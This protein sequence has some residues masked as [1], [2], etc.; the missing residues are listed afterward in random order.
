MLSVG[1]LSGI[2]IILQRKIFADQVEKFLIY[3][4]KVLNFNKKYAIIYSIRCNLS[5]RE[6]KMS[7]DKIT[8]LYCRLSQDDMLDGESNSI[9]NQKAIL[10]KFANDNGFKNTQFYV[11]DGF[12]GT[13]FNRPDFMRMIADVESGKVGIVITKDLSRLGRDYLLTGQYI[14]MIFPD[15]DVRYIAIND[16]VDTFKSENELM[17]FKNIFNDWYA[18]DTSKKIRAVFK[19]KG[20][21]GKPL[22]TN[23][24]YG[25]VKDEND[26]NH[27][28]ID[29]EA[30]DVV[31]RI[32][33]LCIDG[34]GP[35]KIARIL[36]EDG[37]LIPTAYAESKG[38]TTSG[39][40]FKKPTRWS[41]GT[42]ERILE[43]PEYIGHTVNFRT[44]VKSYKNKKRIDN[45]RSEWAIFENTHE[46][47]ISQHDFDL[48]QELRSHKH[49]PQ[50]CDKV[51]PFSGMV[52]C[53][54]CGKKMYLC[55]SKS[56]S[57]DQEHL[58]CS[59]YANDKEECTAHFIRTAVLQQIVIS[60]INKMLEKVGI[61][62]E[63]F[64]NVSLENSQLRQNS[65]L[66]KARKLLDKHNKRII[67]LDRL[68]TRL[69]EDNV[70]GKISDERFEMLS[71]TYE[72]EQ[73]ELKKA[74]SDL[75]DFI[76]SKERKI[77]DV[78]QFLSIVRKYT[79]ITELTPEIMHEFIEKI[80]IHASDKS[81]GHRK[82]QV[83][84]Y[85]R[86]S[87]GVSTVQIDSRD[88]DKK[89]KTAQSA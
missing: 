12:S 23:P 8:A 64:A 38:Y 70:S 57:A 74:V 42:V 36:T 71:K 86:F 60:E 69:Y 61:D 49:R 18:R 7:T 44:H 31:R 89:V 46:P 20:Q 78:T 75:T 41:E 26:K 85:Y 68:F 53:A 66:K 24:P 9:T 37:I 2:L 79:H 16:N 88:F 73:Q 4:A 47:I 6:V 22:T 54:D 21:S 52:Y 82:Q 32:F 58:K 76:E 50:K 25:Y 5:E 63:G 14:E 1:L 72:N 13:N 77:A 65:E 59:T 39:N 33:K 56:L 83:D 67:E 27:W 81:S 28:V 45:D 29:D 80:V 34:Y 84:I 17:A 62:E 3:P 48:V 10:Q 35:S 51:N 87:V 15:Y 43:K 55:R 19:A 30:A 40:T 11:D